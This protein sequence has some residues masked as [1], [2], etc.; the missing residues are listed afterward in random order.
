MKKI[1]SAI[2]LLGLMPFTAFAVD[3]VD[4]TQIIDKLSEEA[5]KEINTQDFK[6]KTFETCDGI[7]EVMDKYIKDSRVRYPILYDDVMLE[8]SVDGALEKK[9]MSNTSDF[10]KTN[11]QVAWVDESDIVKTDWKRIYY[12]N[13]K[14]KKI[15][16]TDVNDGINLEIAKKINIPQSF[17]GIQLYI[18]W[19]K[20]IIIANGFDYSNKKRY[21]Y[22]AD[23]KTYTIVYDITDINK[24]KLDKLESTNGSIAKT[25]KI[26]DKLY[27]VSRNYVNFYGFEPLA[28]TKAYIPQK[29]EIIASK[30]GNLKIKGK[31]YPYQVTSWNAT[32]CDKIKYVVPDDETLKNFNFEPSFL[33]LSVIDIDDTEKK[34]ETTVILGNIDELYMS[35]DNLYL[36]NRMYLPSP[37]RCPKWAYCIAPWYPT[38]TNTVIH[39]FN[40]NKDDVSYQTTGIIPGTPLNQYSMDE[41]DD[42]F[43]IVTQNYYPE[44]FSSVYVLDKDLKVT[45]KL[46]NL[47]KTEDFKSSRFMGDKL[48]L[49]TFKQI[50]PLFVIDLSDSKSPKVLGEL[51]IPGYS[52][53][54]HPYDE[55]HLIGLGYNTS[56][57][58]FGG[59]FN[60][61]LKVDLY[62][63]SD[64]KNPKQKQTLTLGWYGSYSEA[65]DNPRMFIWNGNKKLL[66]LPSELYKND[67]DNK[68]RKTDYFNGLVAIEIKENWINEK[69][70][71]T[72]ISTKGLEEKRLK[73]CE[74]YLNKDEKSQECKKL[75]DWTTYCKPVNRY[76]PNYCFAD[77]TIGEFIASQKWTMRDDFVNRALYIWD[78]IYSISNNMIKSNDI[79]TF[80]DAGSVELK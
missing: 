52:K 47:G 30:N 67:P 19:N 74:P 1:I 33:T 51:K 38:G 20:L 49:V 68:Y 44:R 3:E 65:I 14:D 22:N 13:S 57:N 60:D 75:L 25:R 71:I 54:L 17:N 76:V 46:D 2:T 24:I 43:R 15:Y 77:S 78:K 62:D 31:T 35:L 40:V 64:F 32:S 55:N 72:H 70:R 69:A 42:E 41:K 21:L 8:E 26:G 66:L 50:D 9:S 10:S 27:V 37:S 45:G 18:D 80:K 48:Y 34:S 61:W 11:T 23:S 36:T 39:K 79:N 4:D 63:I 7:K 6:M 58:K 53:Y 28:D 56:E 12:Y 73:S 16:I 29:T 59:T 5:M